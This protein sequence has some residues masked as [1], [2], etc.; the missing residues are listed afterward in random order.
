VA[1]STTW[2]ELTAREIGQQ[3][4]F[5]FPWEDS[6]TRGTLKA[7]WGLYGYGEDGK[8]PSN[9]N[10]VELPEVGAQEVQ[11]DNRLPVFVAS[12]QVGAGTPAP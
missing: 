9:R 4:T 12:D 11:L 7:C 5:T 3:I 10:V 1:R 8:T 6:P 2:G